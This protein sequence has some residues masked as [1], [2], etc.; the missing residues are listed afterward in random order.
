[1]LSAGDHPITAAYRGDTNFLPGSPSPAVTHTVTKAGTTV[2]LTSS[3]ASSVF[4]QAVT[5]KA[6]VVPVAPG[7]GVPTG[8]VTFRDVTAGVDLGTVTLT[9]GG[10]AFTT[11]S[12]SV[13]SHVIRATYSGSANFTAPPVAPELTQ[14]VSKAPTKANITP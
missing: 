14:T 9:N 4:G 3:D 7:G 8:T 6:K 1:T 12:L 10:A 2:T 13:A 11:S 5:F